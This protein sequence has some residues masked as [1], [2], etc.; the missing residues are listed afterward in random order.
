[1][2]DPNIF[3]LISGLFVLPVLIAGAISDIRGRIFPK[4]YW[5]HPSVV[6]GI[7]TT[8]MYLVLLYLGEY[9]II[10]T[11]VV[12]SIVL[13]LVFYFIALRFGS[14]GD[15]RALWHIAI[16]TP[17]LAVMTTILALAIG[18]A[19]VIFGV[20]F[21]RSAPWAVGIALAFGITYGNFLLTLL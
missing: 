16:L 17:S 19:Q 12:T 14:G 11:F 9:Q 4:Y 3:T 8:L 2:V 7:S 6:A 21:N 18:V 13:S 1:M 20:A 15:Y 5:K 10:F